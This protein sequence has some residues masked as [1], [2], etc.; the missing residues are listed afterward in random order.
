[1]SCKYSQL[2]LP[3]AVLSQWPITTLHP[4]TLAPPSLL[5]LPLLT[6]S[7]LVPLPSPLEVL[8]E[9]MTLTV[10][11]W[12]TQCLGDPT[13]LRAYVA[14][15]DLNQWYHSQMLSKVVWRTKKGP[16]E[17]SPLLGCGYFAFFALV[18]RDGRLG[19]Q[20]VSA[21]M[22][23]VCVCGGGEGGGWVCLCGGRVG[24]F[25]LVCLYFPSTLDTCNIK[26]LVIH[27][28]L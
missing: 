10:F 5:Q 2:K 8:C 11:V 22:V 26:N 12:T 13:S 27:L 19:H 23:C 14:L 3:Y 24:A 15:F 1:M 28:C 20:E 6:T 4:L 18:G 17:R 7:S 16:G 21:V 25:V 9:D